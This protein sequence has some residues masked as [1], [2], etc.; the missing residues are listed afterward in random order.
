[1]VRIAHLADTHLGHKQYN[2][3]E[4]END[5][6]DVLEE[7]GEIILEEKLDIVIHSGDLFDSLSNEFA[8]QGTKVKHV[9][10]VTVEEAA[11][12]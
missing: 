2:L 9:V 11:I 5:I 6:Y 7:I 8:T 3:E 1:M 4:R 12:F 10:K